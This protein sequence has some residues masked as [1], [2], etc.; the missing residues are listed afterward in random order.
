MKS[1]LYS[2]I[3]CA[4]CLC[5]M[6]QVIPVDQR[7][8]WTNVGYQ[9]TIPNP[10]TVLNVM[11]YGAVADGVTDDHGAIAAAI[12]ALGGSAGVVFLPTGVYLLNSTFSLPAGTVLRG[13]G[14]DAT[15]LKFDLSSSGYTCIN[16]GGSA[17]GSF[18]NVTGGLTK[19]S[20][21]LTLADASQFA[22]GDYAELLQDNGAW[23]TNPATWASNSVGQIVKITAISG[24]TLT[25]EQPLRIDYDL[26]LN[27]RIRKIVPK[28]N[29]G[30]ECLNIERVAD[31]S[32]GA[33][34]N[35]YFNMAANCWVKGIESNKSVGSH[36]ILN[37]CTNIEVTGNYIHHSF[38]YNGSGTRGYGVTLIHHSGQNLIENNIFQHLRHAMSVKQG[39]N[40]NVLAYNYALETNRSEFINDYG[41]DIS[42]HGH[43]AFA[44]LF[45]GNVVQNLMIDDYWGPTGPYN[46]Y[47]RNRV[48]WYGIVVT[49]PSSVGQNFVGNEIT[50]SV[51]FHG[52]YNLAGT[53]TVEYGNNVR[54]SIMP[55]GTEVL[56]DVS[57]YLTATPEFWEVADC[58]PSVGVPNVID[59]GKLPAKARFE[60][61]G[62]RTVCPAYDGVRV[63]AK[64]ILEGAYD[65][66][67]GLMRTDLSVYELLPLE[68]PFDRPPWLYLGDETVASVA[69]FPVNV[70]DWVLL[71]VRDGSNVACAMGNHILEQRAGFLLRDGTIAELDGTEGLIFKSLSKNVGY[72][73]SIKTRNHLAILGSQSITFPNAQP[74]DC[75]IPANVAGTGQLADLGNG[76]WGMLAGD[77]DSNGTITIADFNLYASQASVLN[78]Y[79]DGDA[80]MDKS[81]TVTDFN[82]Y[83]ANASVIGVSKIRY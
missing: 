52:M 15:F 23:D 6:A 27:P 63:K 1:M 74:Y 12:N 54:G 30:I 42:L 17:P 73:I 71:E 49:S 41:G 34:Y 64:A 37:A 24:N 56:D 77:F 16:V 80:N 44:N 69:D 78:E 22:L 53:A 43:Y 46:A 62:L 4:Y 76:V 47:F 3:L 32:T 26:T 68:Q 66:P 5:G 13:E 75:T 55:S 82:L 36:I 14:S 65:V 35:I 67:T 39:A 10:A 72:T 31:V 21:T 83:Q 20:N 70:V 57:Y 9:G 51:I 19:E 60:S 33:G 38:I 48:E 79:A 18:V 45:E 29:V 50:S 2:L 59:V 81:V 58:F 25:I 40:G 8:D 11:D 28:Q 61:G 7:V